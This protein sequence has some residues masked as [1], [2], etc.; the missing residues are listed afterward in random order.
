MLLC[1]IWCYYI[2]ILYICRLHNINKPFGYHCW[3]FTLSN[4]IKATIYNRITYWY[5][6]LYIQIYIYIYIATSRL[7]G[8]W[9]MVVSDSF[10]FWPS[11]SPPLHIK[12]YIAIL[13][14]Y[15][16]SY[17]YPS[18]YNCFISNYGKYKS[19]IWNW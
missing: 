7:F 3:S 17:H 18:Q 11:A 5:K 14:I 8:Q 15:I 16:N 1:C 12:Q 2:Y 13:Y 9:N 19:P 4:T 10:T 6:S